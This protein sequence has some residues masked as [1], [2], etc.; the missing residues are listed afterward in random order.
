MTPFHRSGGL[1]GPF[2]AGDLA[3]RRCRGSELELSDGDSGLR[4][5]A[6]YSQ[7]FASGTNLAKPRS[8]TPALSTRMVTEILAIFSTAKGRF[9]TAWA[10]AAPG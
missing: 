5:V 9:Q 1:F 2:L 4:V 6:L 8:R 3:D 7:W 10:W